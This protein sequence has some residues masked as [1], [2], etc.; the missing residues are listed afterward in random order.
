MSYVCSRA[1]CA[2][3]EVHYAWSFLL[4]DLVLGV[5][6]RHFRKVFIGQGELWAAVCVWV[7][8]CGEL[9]VKS[10]VG[11]AVWGG[12]P[13][14]RKSRH[15]HTIASST[16]GILTLPSCQLLLVPPLPPVLAHSSSQVVH[17]RVCPPHPLHAPVLV[18]HLAVYPASPT[19]GRVGLT[20]SLLGCSLL[21]L[22]QHLH[23]ARTLT[24]GH[25][26]FL[27]FFYVH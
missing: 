9:C 20:G 23:S 17:C 2:G 11:E 24:C 10:C 6:Y 15:T 14:T 5:Y 4:E 13:V 21:L 27:L 19:R 1:I 3:N 26:N 16:I 18:L 8:R 25:L 22:W 7:E 12:S